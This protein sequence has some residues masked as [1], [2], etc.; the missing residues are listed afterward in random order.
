MAARAITISDVEDIG[1]AHFR[2]TV[3]TSDA[4][5]GEVLGT[6]DEYCVAAHARQGLG[7]IVWKLIQAGKFEGEIKPFVPPAE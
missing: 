2:C 3:T 5:S 1:S 4:K 6:F 7:P